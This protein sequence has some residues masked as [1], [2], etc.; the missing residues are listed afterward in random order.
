MVSPY[1][2]GVPVLAPGE[3]IEQDVLDYLRS[4]LANGMLLPDPADPELQ[5]V[6]VVAR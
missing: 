6:R 2:R 1:P 4:G 3:A 5:T